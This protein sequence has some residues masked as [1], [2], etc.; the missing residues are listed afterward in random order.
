MDK[1]KNLDQEEASQEYIWPLDKVRTKKSTCSGSTVIVAL[2]V[3]DT[4]F[5]NFMSVVNLIL[6][7]FLQS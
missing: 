1:E 6:L 5:W 7:F 3:S 4:L 2:K